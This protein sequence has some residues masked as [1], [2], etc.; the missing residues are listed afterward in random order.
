MDW[1]IGGDIV[2]PWSLGSPME[3]DEEECECACIWMI[4]L[5]TMCRPDLSVVDVLHSWHA[6]E[7]RLDKG[8]F[9]VQVFGVMIMSYHQ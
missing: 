3:H 4:R 8:V 2:Y 5:G 6:E 1:H 7:C 9:V